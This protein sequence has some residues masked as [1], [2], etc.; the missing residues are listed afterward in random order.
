MSHC[1]HLFIYLYEHFFRIQS[2]SLGQ[3]QGPVAEKMIKSAIVSGEWIFLQVL[4]VSSLCGVGGRGRG[5]ENIN[6][7]DD[8]VAYGFSHFC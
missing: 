6:V 5:V 4:S 3:G 1:Y 7:N 8:K 2:I